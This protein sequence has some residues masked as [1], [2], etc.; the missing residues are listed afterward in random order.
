MDECPLKVV[1]DKSSRRNQYVK[2]ATLKYSKI[3]LVRIL[4]NVNVNH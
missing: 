2:A 1:A 3:L 4:N